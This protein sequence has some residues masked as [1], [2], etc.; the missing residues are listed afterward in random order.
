MDTHE[1]R[2]LYNFLFQEALLTEIN[3][4]DIAYLLMPITS[5]QGDKPS[6]L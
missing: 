2:Q 3:K 4:C 6:T 1:N 5:E